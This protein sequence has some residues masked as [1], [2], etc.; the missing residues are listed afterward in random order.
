MLLC[1]SATKRTIYLRSCVNVAC[2]LLPNAACTK[3]TVCPP[4]RYCSHFPHLSYPFR[5]LPFLIFSTYTTPTT[6][7]GTDEHEFIESA[8][9][10]DDEATQSTDEQHVTN[11]SPRRQKEADSD[12]ERSTNIARASSEIFEMA[13]GLR[14]DLRAPPEPPYGA[15]HSNGHGDL[16]YRMK[17]MPSWYDQQHA[18]DLTRP[19]FHRLAM[20][21]PAVTDDSTGY[22]KGHLSSEAKE[23]RKR[24]R[25]SDY[26]MAPTSVFG[27]VANDTDSADEATQ[28]FEK[29]ISPS[30]CDY[31]RLL[32]DT[33]GSSNDLYHPTEYL[34][35]A[36]VPR[37]GYWL[38]SLSESRSFFQYLQHQVESRKHDSSTPQDQS[39]DTSP[40]STSN[41]SFSSSSIPTTSS[42]RTSSGSKR[43]RSGTGS[44]DEP[45]DKK[46][47]VAQHRP[48]F[49]STPR[50]ACF[51]NKYDPVMYSKGMKF[52]TCWT[53][54]FQNMNR[55]L[56]V[57]PGDTSYTGS[58]TDGKKQ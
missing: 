36:E 37:F 28:E 44:R 47:R 23:L 3:S 41:S 13:Q 12:Q 31:S 58:N 24:S 26:D 8:E 1:N 54:D 46:R 51:F 19:R 42:G 9:K 57:C 40:K 10:E 2:T 53:H 50:L 14:S 56:W 6:M 5:P 35:Y 17:T 21:S 20:E 11:E 34:L 55:L 33:E 38:L 43:E 27:M 32:S 49:T 45:R 18:L 48:V 4:S 39:T 52:K 29:S 16:A 15:A 30:N 7:E 25:L 22:R